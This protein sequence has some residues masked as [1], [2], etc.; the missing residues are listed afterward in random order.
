MTDE[1]NTFEEY[2]KCVLECLKTI[3][4][5]YNMATD[6]E[7]KI[8]YATAPIAYAKNE[9]YFA[10]GM[11]IGPLITFYQSGI[12]VNHD[13]QMGAWKYLTVKR[14]EGNYK[15]RAPIICKIKYT[16][17][18]NALTELQADLLCSQIMQATPFHRPYYTK[19]NGQFVLIESDE[20]TNIS[21]V[22][23]GENADKTSR[24]ELTLTIDRAYINYD[25]KELNSGTIYPTDINEDI[26]ETDDY[27]VINKL[28][29]GASIMNNGDIINGEVIKNTSNG[30]DGFYN[31][32]VADK[33]GKII[34]TVQKGKVK[35][36]M[37]TLEGVK[38]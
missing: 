19:L 31:Y 30:A 6:S 13:E 20:P 15:F 12:E 16:V 4:H 38:R 26:E 28:K 35:L 36:I 9:E 5:D 10:N 21:S 37:H 33:N 32:N 22:E 3:T 14:K 27:Y 1:F 11:N 29:N 2:A 24:R 18:I 34:D 8:I 7:V 25:I 17:T 23:V